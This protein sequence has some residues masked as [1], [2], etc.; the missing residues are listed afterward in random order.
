MAA[1]VYILEAANASQ[2]KRRVSA[3]AV[4][5][6]SKCHEPVKHLWLRVKY[7]IRTPDRGYTTS[8]SDSRAK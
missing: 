2:L 7:L 8:P 1:L 4:S 6:E 5:E 3:L